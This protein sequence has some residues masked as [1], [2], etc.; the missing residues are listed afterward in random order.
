MGVFDYLR[1]QHPL[2]DGFDPSKVE[3]QTKDT[4]D[5]YLSLYTITADGRLVSDDWHMEDVPKAERP[6]PNDDGLLGL[7][8]SMRR[9]VDKADVP[10]DFHGDIHF[11][12]NDGDWNSPDGYWWREYRARFSEG[13][14]LQID[15][16]ECTHKTPP[17]R[18]LHATFRDAGK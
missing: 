16:V 5:Q 13:K 9:I 7:C 6:Y 12:G 17:K 4:D 8:G 18:G 3:W 2:P 15:L 11:Y 14:L 1:C 10:R